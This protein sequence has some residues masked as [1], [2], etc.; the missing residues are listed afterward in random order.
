MESNRICRSLIRKNLTRHWL[1]LLVVCIQLLSLVFRCIETAFAYEQHIQNYSINIIPQSFEERWRYLIF[2]F[3]RGSFEFLFAIIATPYG[4]SYLHKKKESH[5]YHSLPVKKDGLFLSSLLS[6]FLFYA[7][8]WLAVTLISTPLIYSGVQENS[9]LLGLYLQGMV[10]RLA[11]FIISY[12]IAVLS[13]VLCGR[14]F[15]V[16]FLT[17]LFH[18]LFPM[19]EEYFYLILENNLF[20]ISTDRTYFS[21]IFCPFLYLREDFYYEPSPPWGASGIYV[22]LSLGVLYLAS[23]LHRKRKE[24]NVGQTLAFPALV[25]YIQYLFTMFTAF[26]MATLLESFD[27][28]SSEDSSLAFPCLILTPVA[29]FLSRMLLLRTKKVFQKKAFLQCGIFALCFLTMI[30]VFQFDLLGI[31]RRV[32][33]PDQVDRLTVS[34]NGMTFTTEDPEDI[35]DFTQIHKLIISNKDTLSYP[36]NAEKSSYYID[37]YA[38]TSLSISYEKKGRD[39]HRSYTLPYSEQEFIVVWDALEAYFRENDRSQKQ[40]LQLWEKMEQNHPELFPRFWYT[41]VLDGDTGIDLSTAE[42]E[43]LLQ[44]LLLDMAEGG[45]PLI[46]QR[47]GVSAA[48][49]FYSAETGGFQVVILP[50]ELENTFQFIDELA[51]KYRDIK[52]P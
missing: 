31:V 3:L 42:Q 35:A 8:P 17:L 23:L 46:L 39:L 10:F 34:L 33:N 6:G 32:P 40:I 38:C 5:F 25:L 43:T 52:K 7:L 49:I 47:S 24:E 29:F 12:G 28:L 37:P 30:L 51:E 26:L 14:R 48:T 16:L 27:I 15:F 11:M 41:D 44:A 4:F 19:L 18:C 13:T 45:E 22:A 2:P 20:G 36:K 50:S 9:F 1:L 21:D